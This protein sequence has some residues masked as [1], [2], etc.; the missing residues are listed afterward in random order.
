MHVR[1]LILCLLPLHILANDHFA[2]G[3]ITNAADL[4]SELKTFPHGKK[5]F[6]LKATVSCILVNS[7]DSIILAFQDKSNYAWAIGPRPDKPIRPGDTVKLKGLIRA[8][9]PH[10]TYEARFK[11]ATVLQHGPA[12]RP[13]P[14]A[15]RDVASGLFDWHYLVLEGLVRDVYKSDT[16]PTFA[17]LILTDGQDLQRVDIPLV[18]TRFEELTA[19]IGHQIRITGFPN[20][21]ANSV[22]SFAGREF[23][24]SG[25]K[26]IQVLCTGTSDPFDAPKL[27]S[28]LAQT[29]TQIATSGYVKGKGKVI[30][31]W[32]EGNALV[33]NK[34]QD[35]FRIH[36]TKGTMP[37]CGDFIEATGFPHSDNFHIT[38]SHALWK[39]CESFEIPDTTTIDIPDFTQLTISRTDKK[40]KLHGSTVV[41]HGTVRTMPDADVNKNTILIE[42]GASIIP[43]D[44]SSVP[45]ALIRATVGCELA[46]TGTYVMVAEYEHA[47]FPFSKA[48]N[49]QVILSSLDDIKIVRNPP[50][51]T[52]ERFLTVIGVLLAVLTSIFIWNL[53]LRR[54]AVRKGRELMREQLGHV[55]ADLRTEERTRLAVE[56]HDTLAQNLTGVSMEIETAVELRENAPQPMLNHLDMA[57]KALKSCRDELR[58]CLWDLRSQALEEKDM[59]KAILRTLQPHV[60]NPQLVVRFNVP[61]SRLSDNTAHALLRVIRELVINAIR[62]GNAS[63]VKVAGTIDKEKLFCSVTDNG[64]GFDPD[65]APGVLQGHFGLEGI[66]ERINEIGGTF[67]LSS[68]QGKGTRAVI[69]L[70]VPTNAPT[71]V[72]V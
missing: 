4:A 9:N 66:R 70:S 62:H 20:L 26:A 31:T 15:V 56:L 12:V 2:K 67:E 35:V 28:L 24:C 23:H 65:A 25:R 5:R 21:N 38:L 69:T 53:A 43:V 71:S 18:E 47:G 1:I 68:S 59:A 34:Y 8:G 29:T 32:G 10:H 3:I 17:F 55:T 45:Q 37:V 7:S 63:S 51:W 36:H 46:I 22:R 60:G 52:A 40:A 33:R 6:D 64:C 44:V 41:V 49:F 13:T 16:S 39:K 58:N 61:R 19:L 57:A 42:N 48:S 72:G 27:E 11:S 30:C 54:V 14:S 50:W